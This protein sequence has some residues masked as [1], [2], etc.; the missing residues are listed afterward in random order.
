MGEARLAPETGDTDGPRVLVISGLYPRSGNSLSGIFVHRQVAELRAQGLDARVLCPVARR[1]LLFRRETDFA[2]SLDGCRNDCVEGVPVTY[3]PYRHVPHRVSTR[4][5]TMSLLHGLRSAAD[6]VFDGCPEVIHAHWLFPAGH[7]AVALASEWGVPSVVTAH[8]SDVHRYPA[9]NRGVARLTRRTLRRA[10]A[11]VAV[12]RALERQIDELAG[13]EVRTEVVYNG[14]DTDLFHPPAEG[15][16]AA[17]KRVG[18]PEAGTGICSVS[19]LVREKGIC[20]LMEAFR[21]VAQ[22]RPELWLVLVGE[23][24]LREEVRSAAVEHGLSHRVFLPG[25]VEHREVATWLRACDVFTLPSHAEGLPMVV[26]EAMACGLPVVA[27][28]VGGMPEVVD[29]SVGSMVPPQNVDRLAKALSA[30]LEDA[31]RRE[32]MGREA[33]A[34]VRKTFTWERSASSLTE[35]YRTALD[36]TSSPQSLQWA[37]E[38]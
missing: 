33:A 19:R 3:M 30:L 38:P 10:D 18:L 21:H 24:P 25:G 15:R 9:E 20:E 7:A 6:G 37:V 23:G 27:S 11:V 35:I 17:R 29:E 28:R 32:E 36:P 14:V 4:L 8:G 2:A 13:G 26:L 16:R 31:D 34:R 12:C 1:V 5:E 22:D